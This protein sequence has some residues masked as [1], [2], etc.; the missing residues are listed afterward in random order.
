M[1]LHGAHN[2][3]EAIGEANVQQAISMPLSGMTAAA[4]CSMRGR[5]AARHAAKTNL[6][7]AERFAHDS[8]ANLVTYLYQTLHSGPL[9]TEGS[10]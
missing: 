7:L 9:L 10:T 5:L 1:S 6:L 4:R 8:F 2:P 3:G